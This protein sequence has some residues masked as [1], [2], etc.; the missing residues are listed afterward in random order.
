MCVTRTGVCQRKCSERYEYLEEEMPSIVSLIVAF[1]IANIKPAFPLTHCTPVCALCLFHCVPL[2]VLARVLCVLVRLFVDVVNHCVPPLSSPDVMDVYVDKKGRVWLLDF[3]VFGGTTS[4][5]LFE[6][7]EVATL[8]CGGAVA[9][10]V[11]S[12]VCEGGVVGRVQA[13]AGV[14]PS[15]LMHHQLPDDFFN[16]AAPGETPSVDDVVTRLMALTK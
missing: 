15:P 2:C 3:S 5:L 16:H 9:S 1:H 14:R 12:C 6:W 7:S 8:G 11:W 4:P 10:P 13:E